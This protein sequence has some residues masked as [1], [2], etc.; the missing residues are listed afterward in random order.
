MLERIGQAAVATVLLIFKDF[1]P[2]IKVLPE[3]V[4]IKQRVF[5][6]ILAFS[7]MI[8]YECCWVRYFRR[9]RTAQDLY[10]PFAGILLPLATLP[11]AAALILGIYSKNLILLASVVI[12]GI[13]HIG[14]HLQH[15]IPD[16][17]S[18][19]YSAPRN[20]ESDA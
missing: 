8:L 20:S 12:L 10:A 9:E 7:L 5:F 19:A 17:F 18:D 15:T 14:I 11:V 6:W 16:R 13:G 1:N 4:F 2:Y 3:G